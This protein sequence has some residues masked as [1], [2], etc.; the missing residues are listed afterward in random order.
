M[1]LL[2]VIFT[3]TG[4]WDRKEVEDLAIVLAIAIEPGSGNNI[5]ITV[6]N[7]N[8][9]SAGKGSVV[10]SGSGMQTGTKSYRNRSIEGKTMFDAI[11]ELSRQS[12]QQLFFAHNQLII[13]SEDL[14]QKRGISDI[15]DFL[16]R[17]PQIRR[18]TWVLVGRGEMTTLLDEPGRLQTTPSQRIFDIINQ[19]DF[20][21]KYAIK[22]LGDFLEML[23]SKDKQAY[24]AVVEYT[25]NL[26]A[27]KKHEEHVTEQG[28]P[29]EPRDNIELRGTAVFRED[30]MVGWLNPEESRGLLWVRGEVRGGIIDIP[31]PD[32]KN[33]LISL[34][35]LSS[36]TKLEP[37]INDGQ[38]Q[39]NINVKTE[40]NIAETT[41]TMNIA[42]PEKIKE[43][44]K[45][46]GKAVQ[47]EIQ[48]ALDKTMQEYDTD[49]LGFAEAIHRNFPS[50]WKSLG[51]NWSS[52]FPTVEVTIMVD[53]KIR[54]IGLV[55]DPL[56]PR[57]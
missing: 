2:T 44:E 43:L 57:L 18:N 47:A 16:E 48:A 30:K 35:I 55:S 42:K 39:M 37:Q 22:R 9:A 5:K 54:R 56:K 23:E 32:E 3:Q 11:R 21:S 46:V 7:V 50:K 36:K 25:P 20:S 53:A 51:K 1:L 6:Q 12:P 52:T 8:P 19:R 40:T 29:P 14:A 10:G 27:R 41:S 33:K 49:V 28:Q 13:F 17:N 31:S 34:E 26:A 24:T 4:C 45:L 15:I 38:L